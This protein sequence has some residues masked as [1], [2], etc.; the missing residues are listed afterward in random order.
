MKDFEGNKI[1]MRDESENYVIGGNWNTW[2][3]SL[4]ATIKSIQCIVL[5]NGLLRTMWLYSSNG[6][7]GYDN[8]GNLI[9]D[10]STG[11][12]SY[13]GATFRRNGNQLTVTTNST[14]AI[15]IMQ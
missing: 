12:L 6:L 7:K 11:Q 3:T 9:G 2:G 15:K 8:G 4:T 1:Q 13:N 14:S 5:I 10:S